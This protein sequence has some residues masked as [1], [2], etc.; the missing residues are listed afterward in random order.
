VPGEKRK[1]GDWYSGKPFGGYDFVQFVVLDPNGRK[2]EEIAVAWIEEM[3]RAIREKDSSRLITVGM[4]PWVQ[5]WGHLSGFV[6]ARVA[7]KLDFLSVHIYPATAKPA[8]AREALRECAVG[9]PVV[10]EETFPLTCSVAELEKFLRESRE[11]ACGWIGHY[12]G[13]PLEELDALERGQRLTMPQVVM[14][15]WLQ[16]FKQLK[17]E[18]AP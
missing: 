12:D 14:R 8:E 9:K 13:T 10:I 7:P 2:R 18:L 4:L 16:S 5:G 3:T 6:P 17:P 1:P 15:A 11:I